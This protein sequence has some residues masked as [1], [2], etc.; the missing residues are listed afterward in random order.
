VYTLF[1]VSLCTYRL[2]RAVRRGGHVR[3][4]ATKRQLVQAAAIKYV[5]AKSDFLT[6]RSDPC[7]RNSS[8]TCQSYF[9]VLCCLKILLANFF[10]LLMKTRCGIRPIKR[11][12]KNMRR[13][14]SSLLEVLKASRAEVRILEHE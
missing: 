2:G 9:A 8:M 14:S 3:V 7:F 12:A 4:R 11:I 1:G 5:G 6:N 13:I 10:C